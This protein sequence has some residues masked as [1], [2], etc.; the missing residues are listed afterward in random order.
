MQQPAQEDATKRPR[1]CF[2]YFDEACDVGVENE[3]GERVRKRKRPGRKPNPPTQQERRAQNRVAQ[4]NFREREQQ[5][6][7]ERE[8]LWQQYTEELNDL[9]QKLSVAEYEANYLRGWILHMMLDSIAKNGTVPQAWIDT[10]IHPLPHP[11]MIPLPIDSLGQEEASAL[12]PILQL[13]MDEQGNSIMNIQG[14]IALADTAPA[15]APSCPLVRRSYHARERRQQFHAKTGRPINDDTTIPLPP[16]NIPPCNRNKSIQDY[17]FSELVS[18]NT[19]SQDVRQTFP[20][21]VPPPMPRQKSKA[22]NSPSS[23]A[24]PTSPRLNHIKPEPMGF[25]P[26]STSTT[27]TATSNATAYASPTS[28]MPPTL[29][30]TPLCAEKIPDDAIPSP[31]SDTPPAPPSQQPPGAAIPP[32]A[33]TPGAPGAATIVPPNASTSPS[34][35]APRLPVKGTI[36]EP[37]TLKRAEDLAHMPPLQA[38]HILR[39]QLKLG[40]IIGAKIQYA[41]TPT[42][43][44]RVIPHDIRIDYVP[45]GSIRDRMII[46][47]KYYDLDDLFQQL[48]SQSMFVGGDIRN[49]RNWVFDQSVTDKFW[50]VSHRL[51]EHAYD[52]CHI[53]E[54]FANHLKEWCVAQQMQEMDVQSSPIY[55]SPTTHPT[56]KQH[57]HPSQHPPPPPPPYH[58]HHHQYHAHAPNAPPTPAQHPQPPP[59]AQHAPSRSHLQQQHPDHA[60]NGSLPSS[61]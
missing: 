38:A 53:S 47:Q 20:L 21:K 44:Q 25:I 28:S 33:A 55:T 56:Q 1:Y 41:L 61:S 45:A 5:R 49:M 42:A 60:S 57:S 52:D 39:L 8:K 27:T 23:A 24:Y 51:F 32:S 19:S 14:A 4:R 13:L 37:P 48:T 29:T 54:E 10:R 12:P 9:K 6:R 17:L 34:T 30:T 59:A 16:R 7:M 22:S 18:L 35:N 43:L 46:F 50:F 11:S 2:Q 15:S 40:S 36:C 3:N 58:Q 31:L 26:L